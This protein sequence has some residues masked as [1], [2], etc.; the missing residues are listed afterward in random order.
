[1]SDPT[2]HQDDLAYLKGLVAG[3]QDR[4][5]Q[6]ASALVW[7][8]GLYGGQC[9]VQWFQA[10]GWLALSPSVSLVVGLGPTV[11]FLIALTILLRRDGAAFP[12]DG[13]TARAANGAFAAIG[14]TNLAMI[15][16]FGFNAWKRS[17]FLIWELYPAVV[18]AL[19]G[20]AWITIYAVRR[21]GWYLAVGLGWLISAVLLG[22]LVGTSSYVLVAALAL[23]LLMALPGMIIIRQAG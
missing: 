6:A 18:F 3:R 12:S 10:I 13:A 16:V 9:F 20:A 23:I 2:G 7:G 17:D 11:I 1:M 22:M 8:G 19:Q 15:I 4:P 21:Q 5:L 14:L